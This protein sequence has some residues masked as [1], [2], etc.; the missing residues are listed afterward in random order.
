[1]I[2]RAQAKPLPIAVRYIPLFSMQQLDIAASCTT[3]HR[4][5]RRR[6]ERIPT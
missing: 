2:T 5:T 1:M 6:P 4:T 3:I